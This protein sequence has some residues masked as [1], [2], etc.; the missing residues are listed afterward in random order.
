MLEG[1]VL[2]IEIVESAF[3][4]FADGCWTPLLLMTAA[5]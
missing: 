1:L 4:E 2:V 3:R 5:V